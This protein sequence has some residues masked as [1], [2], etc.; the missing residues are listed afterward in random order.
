LKISNSK[1]GGF[2]FRR[3]SFLRFPR[4]LLYEIDGET[5]RVMLVRHNK[6]HPDYGMDRR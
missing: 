3:A 6:R 1:G 2:G 5:L 4:H